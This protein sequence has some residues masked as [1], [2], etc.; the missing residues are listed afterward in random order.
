MTFNRL[1]TF[2]TST[3][4]LLVLAQAEE[5]QA[6]RE[7]LHAIQQ[8]DLDAVKRSIYAGADVNAK[9]KSGTSPLMHAAVYS[10]LECMRLLL[11]GGAAA[12]SANNAG[13][14]ALMWSAG[15]R[16]KVRLLLAG[17]ASVKAQAK[18]GRTPLM[19]AASFAGNV[20]TVKLL[21]SKG[22]EVNTKNA[23]TGGAVF[24]AANAGDEAI[25]RVLLQAGGDPNER[26]RFGRTPLMAACQLGKAEPARVLLDSGANVNDQSGR[27]PLAK[28]GLQELGELTPVLIA[29]A[30]GNPQLV[31]LLLDRGAD[32]H[33]KD[34][35]GMTPLM[36]AASSEH[37]DSE[38]IRLLI[39]KGADVGAKANDGQTASAW[40]GKWGSHGVL[41]LLKEPGSPV[42][43]VGSKLLAAPLE[44]NLRVAIEKSIAL[45]QSSSAR[46]FQKSGCIGCH[47]Q[48]LTSM[49]AALARDRGVKINEQLAKERVRA[50]L[51]V[52]APERE[53]SLQAITPGGAPMRDTLTL[54][55]LA[56]ERHPADPVTAA[57]AHLIAGMQSQDGAWR[58]HIVRQP[59]Q[60]SAISE[61]AYAVRALQLYGPVGRKAEYAK[62]VERA[63]NW[64]LPQKPIYN[65][66]RVKHLLGLRWS[67]ARPEVI[68]KASTLLL[69]EQQS[70]GG[71]AQR[72]GF[73][74][75]AYATGQTLFA[76]NQAAG[77][78]PAHPAY[79]RGVTYL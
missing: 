63:R 76:L 3:F 73:P 17:G 58:S 55:G 72:E 40:A 53:G 19:I 44:A 64:L 13:A 27:R 1:V 7:L 21:L 71:W 46:Y 52:R 62:R 42:Q 33:A 74:S 57:A 38:T 60:Y 70:D 78:R 56:A 16:D 34:M 11:N 41:K 12:D 5:R 20:E 79:Q 23:S 66:D 54:I 15:N 6:D 49:A 77:I 65:E 68:R 26:D 4:L 24:A 36:M 75:D 30:T 31:K 51:T 25:L 2:L 9:D 67:D 43:L 32:V 29:A 59:S 35:R 61:T 37:Q 28:V 22:A 39:A 50:M 45:L 14:T 69:A 10:S 8:S 18:S 47:H 48:P